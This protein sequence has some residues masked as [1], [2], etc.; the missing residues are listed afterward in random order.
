MK[1]EQDAYDSPW[2]DII[3]TYFQEFMAFFFPDAAKDIDW[4][5]KFEFLDKELSQVVRDATLGK[6]LADKLARVWR[7]DG[8]ESWVLVHVEL[9]GQYDAALSKRVF[10]YNYRIFDHHNRPVASLVVLADERPGWRP[11]GFGYE[12]WGC[13][14]G[15]TYPIVKL[16]DY[17]DRWHELEGSGNPFAVAVMAH[18]KT[19]ATRGD[20]E[21]RRK[22]KTYLTKRLYR[23]G[24]DKQDVIN[25]F[26][27][28]DW[29]MRLPEEADHAFWAEIQAFEE[30]EKMKYVSSVEKIGRKQGRIEGKWETIELGLLLKFGDK[31]M[32]LMPKIREIKD[33]NRLNMIKDIVAASNSL[34]D[35]QKILN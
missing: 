7:M 19:R 3:E 21:D 34:D 29:M 10:T 8:E 16:T 25:L 1:P 17:E 4:D 18:I 32:H 5:R 12:L 24:Y 6:R 26:H 11:D 14:V 22:W 35:V 9:Q 20:P 27:F 31:G 33:V 30:E 2:K 13:K 15:I 23:L 28:I